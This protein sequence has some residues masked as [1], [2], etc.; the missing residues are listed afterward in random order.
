MGPMMVILRAPQ[1]P[2]GRRR[3]AVPRRPDRAAAIAAALETNPNATRYEDARPCR[4]RH[5]KPRRFISNGMCVE[6]AR[7]DYQR[8]A[9]LAR[10]P[11][12]A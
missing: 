7:E 9:A 5:Q 2:A 11:L 12:G 6:C 1:P 3:E 4:R 8:K 10:L